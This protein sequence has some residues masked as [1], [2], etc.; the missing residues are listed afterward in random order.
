M[1]L[2]GQEDRLATNDKYY[3]GMNEEEELSLDSDHEHARTQV[4]LDK[5]MS[6]MTGVKFVEDRFMN[7]TRR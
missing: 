6:N 1:A 5:R 3:K 2:T 7:M 4:I